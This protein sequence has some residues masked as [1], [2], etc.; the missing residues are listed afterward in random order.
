MFALPPPTSAGTFPTNGFLPPP[1]TSGGPA[2]SIASATT[3]SF[4]NVSEI[5]QKGHVQPQLH[6]IGTNAEETI[7]ANFNGTTPSTAQ[8]TAAALFNQLGGNSGGSGGRRKRRHRT[9]F[10]EE[11]LQMLEQAFNVTQYPGL[12]F[13]SINYFSSNLTDVSVRERLAEQCELREERVEVWFKN[14]R[15]KQRLVTKIKN[16]LKSI[17]K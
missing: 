6:N 1:A 8:Q 14:R 10:S 2:T 15:A 13:K 4:R 16:C 7:H 11:Q 9:I 17:F 12:I 5:A 3:A